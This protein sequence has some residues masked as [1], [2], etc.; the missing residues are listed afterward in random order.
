MRRGGGVC[1]LP[2]SERGLQE[3]LCL[4]TESERSLSFLSPLTSH[5]SSHLSE[6]KSG[7]VSLWPLDT[8]KPCLPTHCP[9]GRLS[10]ALAKLLQRRGSV[11]LPTTAWHVLGMLCLRVPPRWLH[12]VSI[13]YQ[14]AAFPCQRPQLTHF[15]L[16]VCGAE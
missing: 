14:A 6:G 16:P 1:G 13:A 7:C 2:K 11:L 15:D 12:G 10:P 8:W 5:Q 9:G 3:L 4:L